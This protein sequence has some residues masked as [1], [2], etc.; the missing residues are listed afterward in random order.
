MITSTYTSSLF[1]CR[2]VSDAD[3]REAEQLF[4]AAIEA[5]LGG[6]TNVVTAYA[7]YEAAFQAHGELPLPAAATEQERAAVEAWEDAE[8]AG[9]AAAFA[10]WTGNLGGAHF[11]IN[12]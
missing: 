9:C 4:C 5:Q 7:A 2:G 10:G 12:V 8:R 1:D 6:K 3:R 11:E